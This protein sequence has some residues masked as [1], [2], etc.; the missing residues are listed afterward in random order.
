MV[1]LSLCAQCMMACQSP[2]SLEE[3]L[4]RITEPYR[5]EPV[6]WSLR[7]LVRGDRLFEGAKALMAEPTAARLV[8]EY[9]ANMD[10]LRAASSRLS[11]LTQDGDSRAAATAVADLQYLQ[12]QRYALRDIVERIV[13][14]Q[15][16]QG[17]R[18]EDIHLG[19]GPLLGKRYC[20]PPVNFEME[21]LPHLLV[22][23]PRERIERSNEVLLVQE[24]AGD[25]VEEIE[26]RVDALGVS[27]LVLGLGGFGGTYPTLVA[28]EGDLPWVLSTVVEEWFHQY[29]V[30]TPLG[31]A[32]LL[33]Y[34]GIRPNPDIAAINETLAGIFSQEMGDLILEAYYPEV[35]A[36]RRASSQ[37]SAAPDEG[38][39]D[40]A[41]AMREIRI[42]VDRLLAEGRITEAEDYMRERQAY[43][44]QN[45]YYIRK[46]NQAY[47]AFYGTYAAEPTSVD[48]LGEQMREL[49]RQSPSLQAFVR[50]ASQVTSRQELEDLLSSSELI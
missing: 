37:A 9:Y 41:S 7:K 23:S 19:L 2:D 25:D 5:F 10:A 32:Y 21:E 18:S 49:R 29:L 44:L 50:S 30:F 11:A 13:G 8:L 26:A 6:W 3:G 16:C 48:P 33:D 17:L 24:L 35:A 38:G 14:E 45:G 47:F 34:A 20:F 36:R 15:V 28:D 39:F 46:L 1:A 43:L 27:S 4:T 31:V 22:V 12:Q 42:T 40:F